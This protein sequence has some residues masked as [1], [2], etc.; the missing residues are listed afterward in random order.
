MPDPTL[1]TKKPIGWF[2]AS[3]GTVAAAHSAAMKSVTILRIDP[4]P[5]WGA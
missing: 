1:L 2:C 3:A 4:P 5:R